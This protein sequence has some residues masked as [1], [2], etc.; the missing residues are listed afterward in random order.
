MK[1]K[2]KMLSFLIYIIFFTLSVCTI[3]F[4]SNQAG[5]QSYG[6]SNRIS[7]YI[8]IK[9]NRLFSLNLSATNLN[10][11]I[12]SLYMP[13]R[14]I[15]HIIEYT[16]LGLFAFVGMYLLQHRVKLSSIIITILL[17]ILIASC[18]E[19]HQAYVV[20]RGSHFSDVCID[21]I[22]GTAGIYLFII[23]KDFYRKL[24][25]CFKL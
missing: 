25:K 20:Q 24:I 8:G 2:T 3:F 13:I 23:I 1:N 6:L 21:V 7:A 15:A 22:S 10:L 4:F 17:I 9:W 5:T 14:K 12:T 11:L 18:D 19:I 16:I